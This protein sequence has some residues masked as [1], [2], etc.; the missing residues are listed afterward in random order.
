MKLNE[1][2]TKI[3]DFSSSLFDEWFDKEPLLNSIA[4]TMV[5]ANINKYDEYISYIT[6]ENGDVLIEDLANNLTSFIPIEGYQ[7]DIKEMAYKNNVSPFVIKML[8]NKIL[9]FTR[10]DL[11]TLLKQLR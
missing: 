3:L 8:P 9:L 5:K 2:K 7:I 10:D 11:Q 1:V 6:D 4:K